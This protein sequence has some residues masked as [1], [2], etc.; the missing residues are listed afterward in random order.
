MIFNYLNNPVIWNKFCAT[1]EGLYDRMLE[2]DQWYMVSSVIS[3][4]PLTD[5]DIRGFHDGH[6]Y[7][8]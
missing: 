3:P 7:A 5:P 2:F 8:G 6:I 4:H 1:Y